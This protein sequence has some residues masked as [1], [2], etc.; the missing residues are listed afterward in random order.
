[1]R[2]DAR[3]FLA[4]LPQGQRAEVWRG[5]LEQGE[6]I[7]PCQARSRWETGVA[8]MHPPALHVM[9]TLADGGSRDE[10]CSPPHVVDYV[11]ERIDLQR[12][13]H[14]MPLLTPTL[15]PARHTICYLIGESELL[16]VDPG[17]PDPIEQ[18]RLAHLLCGMLAE[19]RRLKAIVLTHHHPDHVLGARAVQQAFPA[20]I[21]AHRLTAGRWG[22]IDRALED[23]EELALGGE[24][25]MRWTVLHTPGH[26][27]DHLC[28][29][30]PES[31]AAL[32]GDMLSGVSTIIIDP[33]DGDMEA[34]LGSLDRLARLGVRS[35]YPAHGEP[36]PD[37]LQQVRKA[38]DHRRWREE[39]LIAA[40]EQEPLG[41][42]ELTRRVY[43]ELPPIALPFAARSALASLLWLERRGRIG[44]VGDR[45]RLTS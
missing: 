44:R 33:P 43:D 36:M 10:L 19:G 39:K 4:R 14:M 3:F 18:E 28:L 5:E 2:F 25:P 7:Q 34:Y 38:I 8:L 11:A 42:E 35:V 30:H 15:P 23:G 29:F 45:F 13:V 20:P 9:R 27:S 40:L 41:L 24:F 32:C 1:V 31:R 17:S 21:W 6:W 12:G 37:G 22:A 16:L 26:S